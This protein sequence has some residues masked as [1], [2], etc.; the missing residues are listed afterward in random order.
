MSHLQDMFVVRTQP[1]SALTRAMTT[2]V[3]NSLQDRGPSQ[4]EVTGLWADSMPSCTLD[5]PRQVAGDALPVCPPS[6]QG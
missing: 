5:P 1:N 4:Q 6:G 3:P 2:R